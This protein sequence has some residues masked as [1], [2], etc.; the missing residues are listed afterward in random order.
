[1]V[2]LFAQSLVVDSACASVCLR[3]GRGS[4][5]NEAGLFERRRGLELVLSAVKSLDACR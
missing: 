5:C 1:M 3:W 2:S 4:Y